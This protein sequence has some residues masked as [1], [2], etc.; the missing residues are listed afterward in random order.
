MLSLTSR[1]TYSDKP[2]GSVGPRRKVT[3]RLNSRLMESAV[4]FCALNDT[5][6]TMMLETCI[7]M[8]LANPELP[9]LLR[10][11]QS[12]VQ[13][14]QHENYIAKKRIYRHSKLL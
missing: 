10:E 9:R 2:Y 7:L 13:R 6:L 8:G 4:S 11:Q 14:A 1:K 12:A 3:A 5:K